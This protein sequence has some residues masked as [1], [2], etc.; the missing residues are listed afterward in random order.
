M[1]RRTVDLVG[2][3][4]SSMSVHHGK[5]EGRGVIH[6]GGDVAPFKTDELTAA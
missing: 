4:I 1:A 5:R 3:W 6:V 2:G